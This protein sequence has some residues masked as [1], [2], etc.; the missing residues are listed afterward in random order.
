[1]LFN[2]ELLVRLG[3]LATVI[4]CSLFM[5]AKGIAFI[6]VPNMG[7]ASFGAWFGGMMF[8]AIGGILGIGCFFYAAALAMSILLD[9]C[10]GLKR[11]ESWPRGFFFEWLHETGYVAGAVFWGALPGVPLNLLLQDARIPPVLIFTAAASVLFP[12]A[13]MGELETGVFCFPGAPAVW[14]SPFR[15]RRAWL[16]FY[17]ITVPLLSLVAGIA[18]YAF[19][20]NIAWMLLLASILAAAGWLLYFRLLGRLAWYA[21]GRAETSD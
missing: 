3:S 5:L 15:A 21:S 14:L 1:M 2:F 16:D 19:Q 12:L 10:N 13:L 17:L 11:I 6:N 7:L 9:T 8:L 4:F 20:E 18:A